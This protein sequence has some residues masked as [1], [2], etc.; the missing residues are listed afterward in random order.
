MSATTTSTA[1]R[2]VL[3][4]EDH[5]DSADSLRVLLAIH[6]CDVRVAA[7]ALEGVREAID[8]RPDVVISDINLPHLNGWELGRQIRASLG[9]EVFLVAV[10]GMSRAE[11]HRRS[12]E[13][14]FNAH[15]AKPADFNEI[16]GLIRMAA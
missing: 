7:D 15:L 1:L 12:L 13:A 16:L 4:I 9:A 2:R 11:D 6:G 10:S 3:I 14:G 5:A 8:W